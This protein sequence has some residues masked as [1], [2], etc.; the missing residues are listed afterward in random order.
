MKKL[1]TLTLALALCL[2]LFAGCRNNTNANGTGP[3]NGMT[4]FSRLRRNRR[5]SRDDHLRGRK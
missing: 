4:D 5:L 2:G 1:M 3:D